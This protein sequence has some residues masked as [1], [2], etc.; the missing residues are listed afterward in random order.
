MILHNLCLAETLQV[1]KQPQ[2]ITTSSNLG[3]G[4]IKV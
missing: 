1:K 3:K 2:N 4:N